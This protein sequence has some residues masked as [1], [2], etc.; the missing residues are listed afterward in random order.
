MRDKTVRRMLRRY[1]KLDARVEQKEQW[2]RLRKFK[3]KGH[4]CEALRLQAQSL[5][6]GPV[7]QAYAP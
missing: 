5:A 3:R 7:R 6:N 1:R 2:A 4:S